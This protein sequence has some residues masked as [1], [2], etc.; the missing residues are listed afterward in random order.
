MAAITANPLVRLVAIG[1]V[2]GALSVLTFHQ[3]G[4]ALVQLL[5][6]TPLSLYP[7]RSFG[8][9]GVPLILNLAFWGG[10]W[11]IVIW[12]AIGRF[13]GRWPAWAIG[14]V[15][16]VIGATAVGWFIAAAI[17]GQDISG[18]FALARIWRGPLIN[19]VFGLGAAL[20]A[21]QLAR[22]I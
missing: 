5:S 15:L 3:A 12:W 13:G 8:P 19:G 9:F 7:M 20:I 1:F 17:K 22:R 21:P 14:L 2:A 10:V 18:G 11:G 6:G 16:G 4:V